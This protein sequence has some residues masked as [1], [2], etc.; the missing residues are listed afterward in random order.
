[1]RVSLVDGLNEDN[2][3]FELVYIENEDVL[4]ILELTCIQAGFVYI[5]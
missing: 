2:T 3:D 4:T 5:S 1:M